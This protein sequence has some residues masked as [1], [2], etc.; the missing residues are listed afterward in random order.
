MKTFQSSFH[1]QAGVA[2]P[3]ALVM[4]LISTMVGL[5]AIRSS[6]NQEKMSANMYD[7]SLAY[8]AA[9]G[10]LRAAE[11]KILNAS[12]PEADSLSANCILDSTPACAAIPRYTFSLPPSASDDVDWENAS[13]TF[14]ANTALL[15]TNSSPQYYIE[16]IGLVGGTDE[17]GVGSSA[18]CDNY[19]GCDDTPPTAMLFRITARSGDPAD[20][21]GRAIVALQAT[22]KQNL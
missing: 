17:L 22:V 10:A 18:N 20:N 14:K 8:Q 7:R 13:S 3:V 16:R 6:I 19:A 5:A 15:S 11:E 12:D 2:L 1:K 4:L 21:D 9:E